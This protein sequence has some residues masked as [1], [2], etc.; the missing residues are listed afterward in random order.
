[1]SLIPLNIA[2]VRQRIRQAEEKS[3][4]KA[5]SVQLLAASKTQSAAV[6]RQAAQVGITNFGENYLQEALEKITQLQDLNLCWHFIGPIQSNKTRDIAEHF[7][8]IHSVDRLKVAQRL[9]DQRPPELT[10]LNICLQINISEEP[11]KSGLSIDETYA[12]AHQISSLPHLVVRGLMAIPKAVDDETQQRQAY[13]KLATIAAKLQPQ[14]PTLDTLSM[15]MS[16][17]LESAIAE[18]STIVRI[19]TDIF[20][21]RQ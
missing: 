8:W 16:T 6:I 11:T 3:Q 20:G 13:A 12:L 19:G 1:M 17:D 10:P 15:G 18:G 5:G 4:R 9:S 7:S 14:I 2:K 21:P